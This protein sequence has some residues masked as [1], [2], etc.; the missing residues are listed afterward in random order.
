MRLRFT[1]S[2]RYGIRVQDSGVR[3]GLRS[4]SAGG[5]RPPRGVA[6]RGDGRYFRKCSCGLRSRG[7]RT[8]QR[9]RGRV[10]GLGFRRGRWRLGGR[11]PNARIH[12]SR[13]PNALISKHRLRRRW[14]GRLGRP[15]LR[16]RAEQGRRFRVRTRGKWDRRGRVCHWRVPPALAQDLDHGDG[17]AYGSLAGSLWEGHSGDPS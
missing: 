13:I 4:G 9:G 10:Q 16:P 15:A 5:P 6:R 17:A 12:E 2:E 7:V 3:G 8:W 11:L 14:P 1:S